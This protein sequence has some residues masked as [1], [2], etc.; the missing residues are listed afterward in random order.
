MRRLKFLLTAALAAGICGAAVG[1]AAPKISKAS[2]APT[3]CNYYIGG[4]T[5][6]FNLSAGGTEIIGLNEV[7]AQDGVYRP[8]EKAGLRIGD[9]ICAV[10]GIAVK[11]INDLNAA[12][13]RS[14]G[15]EVTLTV[16]RN[17]DTAKVPITP[18]KDKKSS[19]YKIGVLIR[20]TVSGIGTVTYIEKNSLRFASL[21]HAVCDEDRN[22]LDISDPKVTVCSIV[23]VNKGVRGK[24]GELKGLFIGEELGK[25]D[26][27]CETGLYGTVSKNYDLS[28][29]E[30]VD[31]APVSEATIGKAIIYSTIDGTCPQ[32]YEINIAKVDAN[33]GENKN[34][35]IKVTD[36]K[37]ISETGGIVQG[38]SGSPIIQ[39][40]KLIGAV[41]HVFL[42]DPTRGYGIAIENMMGK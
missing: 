15:K 23:G 18:V 38:M 12:L 7:V 42:N 22:A 3:Q 13:E 16:R 19:R 5:A 33:N 24:A 21:G 8:A 4:M 6:G 41:T 27:V 36:E 39:N 9:C 26:R 25:A 31:I 30:A 1:T 11:S 14:A 34:F 20:D 10:E 40:G 32:K 2:A 35:V 28:R 37:L 17:G 29:L